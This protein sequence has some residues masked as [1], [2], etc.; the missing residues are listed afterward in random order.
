MIRKNR[1]RRFRK[2]TSFMLALAVTASLM[3]ASPAFAEDAEFIAGDEGTEVLLSSAGDGEQYLDTEAEI[4]DVDI[5]PGDVTEG[6]DSSI[7]E[8]DVDVVLDPEDR[9]SVV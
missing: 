3:P 8:F 5:A 9:K 7:E 6:A 2:L 1:Q 4:T